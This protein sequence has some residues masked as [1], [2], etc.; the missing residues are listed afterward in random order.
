MTMSTAWLPPLMIHSLPDELLLAIVKGLKRADLLGFASVSTRLYNLC[1]PNL[2]ETVTLQANPDNG[3][4]ADV[5]FIRHFDAAVDV[6]LNSEQGSNVLSHLV[7]Y[8]EIR[9]DGILTDCAAEGSLEV[10]KFFKDRFSNELALL[11]SSFMG[12]D[13][14]HAYIPSL[15]MSEQTVALPLPLSTQ[16]TPATSA[17]FDISPKSPSSI[18]GRILPWRKSTPHRQQVE[19]TTPPIPSAAPAS[20]ARYNATFPSISIEQWTLLAPTFDI[21]LN[22]TTLI[23]SNYQ[24]TMQAHLEIDETIIR[25]H[26]LPNLELLQANFPTVTLF[27]HDPRPLRS[28]RTTILPSN[29]NMHIHYLSSLTVAKEAFGT[30]LTSLALAVMPRKDVDR[31]FM[32]ALAECCPFLEELLF[33]VRQGRGVVSVDYLHDHFLNAN[34]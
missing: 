6:F 29:N 8:V 34:L 24:W 11:I 18:V 13:T 32:L 2:F 20:I 9:F 19:L 14:V 31:P 30:F 12:L 25:P 3:Y 21:S 26:M 17:N 16:S 27:L 22:I 5:S 23:L 1:L 4:I 10:R 28:I 33:S 7:R 15:Y